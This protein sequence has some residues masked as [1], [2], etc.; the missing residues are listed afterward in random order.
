VLW[1]ISIIPTLG[2]W[3]QENHKFKANP[4]I[5]TK[6]LISRTKIKTKELGVLLRR[7]SSICLV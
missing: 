2:R 7:Q 1:C 5:V 4:D 3:R 6:V